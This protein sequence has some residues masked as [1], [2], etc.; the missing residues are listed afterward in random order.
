MINFCAFCFEKKKKKKEF[1]LR[2]FA[3]AECAKVYY[4]SKQ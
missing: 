3:V 2:P 1:L 4:A